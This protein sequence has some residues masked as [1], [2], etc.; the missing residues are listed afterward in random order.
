MAKIFATSS[1]TSKL[2]YPATKIMKKTRKRRHGGSSAKREA[3]EAKRPPM[4]PTLKR[5]LP[6]VEPLDQDQIEK[7]DHESMRI[8]EEVGVIYRDEIAL[9][10]WKEAGANVQGELVKA[11]RGLILSLI[12]I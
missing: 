9:R 8:L 7:I 1:A 5:N 4:L 2:R 3:I 10:Q 6:V 12:H 11:D